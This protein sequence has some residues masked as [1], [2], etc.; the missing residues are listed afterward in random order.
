MFGSII[1]LFFPK[2]EK[3]AEVCRAANHTTSVQVLPMGGRGAEAVCPT[4]GERQA[5]MGEI[6]SQRQRETEGERE[7]E[8]TETEKDGGE[9]QCKQPPE[10]PPGRGP[11]EPG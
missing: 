6:K 4:P 11:G 5:E 10:T 1:D 2:T 3:R 7:V 9:T 8:G